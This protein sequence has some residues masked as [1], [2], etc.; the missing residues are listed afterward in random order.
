MSDRSASLYGNDRKQESFLN[1]QAIHHTHH[2]YCS[3]DRSSIN[4]EINLDGLY[5]K[6]CSFGLMIERSQMRPYRA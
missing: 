2:S 4:K 3:Y 6:Y 1:A 5:L